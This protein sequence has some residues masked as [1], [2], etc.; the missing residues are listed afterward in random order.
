VQVW[1]G[2]AS[3]PSADVTGDCFV[4]FQ[5][6][7]DVT[8]QWLTG[9]HREART[10][11]YIVASSDAPTH[12]KAEADYVCN[13]V[14]DEVE[15]QAAIDSLPAEPHGGGHVHL[16]AGTFN[17]YDTIYLRRRL[18][19]SGAGLGVTFLKLA[20]DT[21]MFEHS[22][23]SS[24]TW[25]VLEDMYLNGDNHVGRGI[26]S[27]DHLLDLYIQRVAIMH[28]DGDAIY[29]SFAWGWEIVES[30]IEFCTGN[31]IVV[32]T[33]DLGDSY[34]PKIANCKIIDNEK[35]AI[36]LVTRGDSSAD[37]ALIVNC[38]LAGLRNK[39]ND[40]TIYVKLDVGKDVS[41]W[42]VGDSVRN[43]IGSGNDWTGKVYEANYLG[44]SD[45]IIISLSTGAY[46]SIDI[47]DGIENTAQSDTTT[48]DSKVEHRY[49]AIRIEKSKTATVS[50]RYHTISNCR[51]GLLDE[52][53]GIYLNGN[54]SAVSG[55]TFLRGQIHIQVESYPNTIVGNYFAA[56]G[57][58]S[59]KQDETYNFNV[60]RNN[61]GQIDEVGNYVS[62]EGDGVSTTITLEHSLSPGWPISSRYVFFIQPAN[63]NMANATYWISSVTES[64]IVITFNSALV[65]GESYS[66]YVYGRLM[67]FDW[68]FTVP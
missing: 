45:V 57:T 51:F 18:R 7:A 19:L 3:C 67:P 46:S 64:Q 55:N 5:D 8:A 61:C 26:V 11:T 31:G 29:T 53:M 63:Q 4:D 22:A 14:N 21:D 35:N 24:L 48:I 49:A 20:A 68:S 16:S 27:D 9:D 13:G 62:V 10:A 33:Q 52:G 30:V 50:S 25:C 2:R 38:E 1:V 15:I 58:C 65:N 43:N 37:G 56:A 60:I 39:V 54:R 36:L 47:A 59:I 40:D 23:A 44:D 6:L 17:I 12:V 66:F 34:G 41:A 32:D 28:F 42:N